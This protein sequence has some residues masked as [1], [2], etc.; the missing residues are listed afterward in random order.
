[1]WTSTPLIFV[2]RHKMLVLYTLVEVCFPHVLH[3]AGD[4]VCPGLHEA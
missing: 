3:T 1:M 4:I 2:Y